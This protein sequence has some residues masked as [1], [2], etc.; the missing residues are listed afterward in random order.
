MDLVLDVPVISP[1][2]IHTVQTVIILSVDH[3]H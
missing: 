2:N 3:S 1:G